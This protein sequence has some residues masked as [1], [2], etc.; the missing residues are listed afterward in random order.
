MTS[1]IT[2]NSTMTAM[3]R[4]ATL[5]LN[6]KLKL[7]QSLKTKLMHSAILSYPG[8]IWRMENCYDGGTHFYF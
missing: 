3:A 8:A 6:L 5:T 4:M 2:V 1:T 7:R